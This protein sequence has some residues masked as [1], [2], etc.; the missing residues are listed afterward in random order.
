[1][2]LSL[3]LSIFFSIIL[4]PLL[5]LFPSIMSLRLFISKFLCFLFASLYLPIYMSIYLCH[6]PLLFSPDNASRSIYFFAFLERVFVSYLFYFAAEAYGN[7]FF[8]VALS[9]IYFLSYIVQINT[10]T[11]AILICYI[12]CFSSAFE[13]AMESYQ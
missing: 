8:L 1:M 11:R 13:K 5:Y 7:L 9:G 4:S 2:S 3:P 10:N 12:C 6:C